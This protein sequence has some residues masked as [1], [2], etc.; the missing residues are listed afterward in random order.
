MQMTE[1]NPNEVQNE[2]EAVQKYKHSNVDAEKH[3]A[4]N[5]AYNTLNPSAQEKLDKDLD[6]WRIWMEVQYNPNTDQKEITPKTKI[7]NDT[8]RDAVNVFACFYVQ[9][10]KKIV[11]GDD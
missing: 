11:G 3:E 5:R 7:E 1:I 9:E 8:L 6:A 10:F 4:R 2:T